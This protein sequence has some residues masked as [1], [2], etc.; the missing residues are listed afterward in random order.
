MNPKTQLKV[1]VWV[2]H[3][4]STH[5]LWLL[6]Q[7]NPARGGFWQPITGHVESGESLEAAAL[8]ELSEETGLAPASPPT[9][10]GYTFKFPNRWAKTAS[11]PAECEEHSFLV[12]LPTSQSAGF[13]PEITLDPHEHVDSRWVDTDTA[14]G[15]L[16]WESNREALKIAA[17][18]G[19][20]T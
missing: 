4:A 10:I 3:G 19:S 13:P 18:I 9:Q 6:L 8:R 7:C 14:L 17:R 11:D 5:P 16:R 1:Q 12:T 15:M 20:R 2:R